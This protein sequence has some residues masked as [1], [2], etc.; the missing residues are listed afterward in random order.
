[1][2]ECTKDQPNKRADVHEL[3]VT[4][5]T[6]FNSGYSFMDASVTTSYKCKN[7]SVTCVTQEERLILKSAGAE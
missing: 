1:M 4:G 6:L 3:E 7:C 2:I 5:I